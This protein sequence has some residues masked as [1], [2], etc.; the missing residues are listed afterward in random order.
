MILKQGMIVSIINHNYPDL[1]IQGKL[2]PSIYP[3]HDF[4]IEGTNYAL[5]ADTSKYRAL[6]IHVLE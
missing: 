5:Y 1:V 3:K 2:I 6:T 4:I